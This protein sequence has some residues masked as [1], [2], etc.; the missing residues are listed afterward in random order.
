MINLIIMIAQLA[1]NILKQQHLG[2][3]TT[4]NASAILE[5]ISMAKAA[6]EQETGQPL[7]VAKIKPYIPI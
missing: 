4:L 3:P 2:G 7:D 5:I 1:L 6:Y